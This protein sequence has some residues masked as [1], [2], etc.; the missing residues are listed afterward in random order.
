MKRKIKKLPIKISW[1][2]HLAST[3]LML[4]SKQTNI[5]FPIFNYTSPVR[6]QETFSPPQ[7]QVKIN[8]QHLQTL[9]NQLTVECWD[10]QETMYRAF[11]FLRTSLIIE[12]VLSFSI[13]MISD[14]HSVH[15]LNHQNSVTFSLVEVL[16]LSLTWNVS[17]WRDEWCLNQLGRLLKTKWQR[18]A[19]E[20][21]WIR[22]TKKLTLSDKKP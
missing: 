8:L 10:N 20:R 4:K 17:R 1:T 7:N 12:L 19:R 13:V 16:H 3:N 14:L 9:K 22:S 21:S 6:D 5:H 18:R 11:L 2:F 15:P